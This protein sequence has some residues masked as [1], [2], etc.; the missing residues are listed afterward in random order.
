MQ[1]INPLFLKDLEA[2]SPI[3]LELGSAGGKRTGFYGVDHLSLP[4]VD[5]VADLNLPFDLLPDNS[6]HELYS[7]HTLEHVH[8]F[9]PLMREIHRVCRA[10]AKIEIIVPHFSNV[11]GFSD[12]THV[13]FFG[14]YTMNYFV[15][16]EDQPAIRR[17]PA[18]YSD[19]RFAVE[20]VRIEFYRE[21][22]IDRLLARPFESLVNR[23]AAWQHFYERRLCNLFHAWQ[24]IYRM[25]P[26]KELK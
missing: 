22:R 26:M 23:S 10:D 13:R 11:F 20:S 12:P 3:R 17:V 14:L 9:L 24:I 15:A 7:R 19:L 18:F 21:G 6:V 16:A 8:Q 25:H 2:G 4:G 1:I 5:L